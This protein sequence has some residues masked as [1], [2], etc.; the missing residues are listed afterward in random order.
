MNK[1]LSNNGITKETFHYD[2]HD[3]TAYIQTQQDVSGILKANKFQRE[4]APMRHENEVF[5]HKARIPTDAI[6]MWCQ[7]RGIK[8]GQFLANP[9]HLKNF[10]ND[11]DNEAWLTR[12]GKV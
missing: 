1:V 10:M 5:N 7:T 2:A 3:D 9:D 12:K 11:P 6:H 4:N 8:Y